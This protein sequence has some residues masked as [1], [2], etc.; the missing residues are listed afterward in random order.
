[1]LRAVS[2]EVVDTAGTGH[3][4]DDI[5]VVKGEQVDR[6]DGGTAVK[7]VGRG[8]LTV[9]VVYRRRSALLH[10]LFFAF[11]P[12]HLLSFAFRHSQEA[13]VATFLLGVG[14]RPTSP[15]AQLRRG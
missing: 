14:Q 10:W 4:Q 12:L 13:L 1:M 8:W 5:D 15:H 2:R 6:I 11:L 9:P 7:S 3:T